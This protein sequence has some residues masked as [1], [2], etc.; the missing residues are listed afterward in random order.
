MNWDTFLQTAVS[1]DEVFHEPVQGHFW[2]FSYP[3][4]DPKPGE[5]T[6]VVIATTR[7]ETMLGDTAVAVHPNPAAALKKAEDELRERLADAPA[8]E[9][10]DLQT[11]LD[12]VE[13][14]RRE[15][16]PRLETLRDMARRGVM[17]TLPLANRPIPLIAD[18]W[19][20]PELGSGCVKIT[21]A[22]DENDYAVWQR[23]LEIGAW[24]IMEPDGTLNATVPEK[25]RGLKMA[26]TARDAVVSDMEREGLHNPETDCEDRIIDLAHSDRSK[27]PIEPYLADQWFVKMDELAQSAID[28][29]KDGRVKIIPERYAKGYIDWLSEKRDWPIG[30]QLWWGHRIPVWTLTTN[31]VT[32]EE[33]IDRLSREED[34]VGKLLEEGKKTGRVCTQ[35][36]RGKWG[37]F[38]CVRDEDDEIAKVLDKGALFKREEDVLDTWFSSALWPHSTLGWPEQTEELKYYYPTSVLITNRDILTL[39]VARMV[40]M[41]LHNVGEVPFHEVYIHP[42]ILDGY[43]EGMSKSKGNGVDPID[44]IEKFGADALRF[45]LA[46]LTTETQD[47]RLPVEFECPSC[48]KLIEQTRENRMLPRIKCKHC[49]QPF[50]TQWAEKP[51]DKALPRGAMVNDRFELARNFCNKLWNASRF[52]LM[53]LEGFDPGR[54][55]DDELMVEDSWILSRLATVTQQVTDALAEYRYADAAGTLNRFAWDEFCSFYVEMVKGRL[56]DESSRAVAQRLLAHVLDTLLRLLHPM[57]PFLT[58]EVW[59]RLAAVVPERGIDAVEQAAESVMIAPWPECDPQRQDA[60]IEAQFARFQEVLRAVRDIR[61]RQG[62]TPKTPLRFSVRCD[63]AVAELLRPMT[64]YFSSMANAEATAFGPDTTA[65]ALSAHVP[66][67]GMEVYIDLAGLIDL[68]AERARKRQEVEK[69]KGFV[70]A[71][72]KKLAQKNFVD[73]A[74]AEVVQKERDSLADLQSQLAAA[75]E[76][77]ERL[78][79]VK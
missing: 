7:P 53:N 39:W 64:A 41:G 40:L 26:T 27:T 9:K 65:P 36:D 73:R 29:V 21:P 56:Q 72:E 20:K 60:E 49:G 14:R 62:V 79:A 38:I 42:K 46:Y 19:A 51:E 68:E 12:E 78:A 52:A 30:R 77:L 58:E 10:P 63:A 35:L 13:R 47:I 22:H 4:V 1:D 70:A 2:H 61:A 33:E 43:G 25:Y 28:A 17:L 71:K 69:L 15:M 76:V 3:V 23:H 11:Q 50:S 31:P 55:S 57:I 16:L 67:A 5:P 8:K 24:N 44:V 54:V 18:E 37:L 66:L 32:D 48:Q 34:E 59:Q 74:P 6:H 75:K 45:G